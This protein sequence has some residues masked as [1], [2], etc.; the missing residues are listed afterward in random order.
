MW[1]PKRP[2]FSE[3]VNVNEYNE[4]EGGFSIAI[5][6]YALELL[7]YNVQ[8]IFKPFINDKGEMNGTYDQ[9]LKHIEGQV[10][11]FLNMQG[12]LYSSN[13]RFYFSVFRHCNFPCA[14]ESLLFRVLFGPLIL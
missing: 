2:G 11:I 1:V 9:L 12:H 7:P 8:P 5:F 10:Y 14:A 13:I 4:V 6:C 3:F